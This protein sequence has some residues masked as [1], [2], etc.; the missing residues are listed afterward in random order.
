M[1]LTEDIEKAI[2]TV[3]EGGIILYPTDTIWGLG[4]DA[5]NEKSVERIYRIK[6]RDLS[7]P[8]ICLVSSIA[9][10]K[11]YVR[12]VHPRV[13]TLL[14]YHERPLTIVYPHAQGLPPILCGDD[15]T[16]AI[17]LVQEPFCQALIEQADKP[18]V[19]TSAN[20]AGEPFPSKFGEISSNVIKSA[21]YVCKYRRDDITPSPPSVVARYD[22]KGQLDFIRT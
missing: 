9:M 2:E 15:G 20:V 18:L 22:S 13:E 21:D 6:K 11:K 10:L 7:K 12:R 5:T 8:L 1:W 3:V 19:S 17:R 4:C 14:S 16:I